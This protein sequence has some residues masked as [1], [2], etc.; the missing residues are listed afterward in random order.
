MEY[1]KTVAT[2]IGYLGTIGGVLVFLWKL[3]GKIKDIADG[4]KCLL[5]TDIMSI[6]YR[7]CDEE[8]PTLREY[9]RKQLD[10]LVEAYTVL[11]GNTFVADIYEQMRH[12]H[13][14]S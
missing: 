2:I 13:V 11:R 14:S 3:W 9:E 1:L 6:Y 12:W 10:A 4:Q 7:H 8:E 5:R